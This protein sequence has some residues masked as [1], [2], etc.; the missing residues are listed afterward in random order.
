MRA[1][2]VT[3]A[4]EVGVRVV[5][6]QPRSAKMPGVIVNAAVLLIFLWL[7]FLPLGVKIRFA[8]ATL[9]DGRSLRSVVAEVVSIAN[10]C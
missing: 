10:V 3:C 4:A 9:T 5:E 1:L 7:V 6:V 2:L 8:G